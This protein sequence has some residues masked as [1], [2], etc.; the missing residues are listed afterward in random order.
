M[1]PGMAWGGVVWGGVVWV[2]WFLCER[3]LCGLC[4]MYVISF[5]DSNKCVHLDCGCV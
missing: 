3:C 1:W 4:D 2:L 5:C